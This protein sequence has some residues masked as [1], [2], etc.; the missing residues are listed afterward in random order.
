MTTKRS[1]FGWAA[2]LAST[3]VLVTA[4]SAGAGPGKPGMKLAGAW[5]VTVNRPA[6]L[7][8]VASLQIYN[9]DG[10]GIETSNEP[11]TSRSP[12]FSSWERIGGRLYAATGVH[13]LFNPQTGEFLG[14]RKINRTIEVAKDGQ[15]FTVV[16]RVTTFGPSGNVLGTGVATAAG[17]RITVERI[18]DRP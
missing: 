5:Q 17:K 13:F 14:T 2:L 3:V 11:P 9:A 16:A 15:S 1:L 6:P 8:P 7:T 18:P 12:M 10:T 4:A